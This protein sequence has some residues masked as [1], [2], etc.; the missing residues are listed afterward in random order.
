MAWAALMRS[1]NQ[2]ASARRSGG[3]ASLISEI[4]PEDEGPISMVAASGR[5]ACPPCR[6]WARVRLFISTDLPRPGMPWISSKP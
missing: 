1:G 4:S 3:S 2:P 6:T 5:R